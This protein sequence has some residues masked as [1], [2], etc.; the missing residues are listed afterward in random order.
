MKTRKQYDQDL[1]ALKKSLYLMGQKVN[2]AL[3]KSVSALKNK[4]E[5]LWQL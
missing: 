2:E 4:D 5:Q 1:R 3:K